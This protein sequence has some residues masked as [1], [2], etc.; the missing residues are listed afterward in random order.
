MLGPSHQFGQSP[1]VLR[2]SC[3]RELKL[4]AAGA[5]KAQSAKPQNALEVREQHLDLLARAPRLRERLS[6]GEGTGDIACGFVHIADDPSRGHVRA[7]LR[8]ER[9]RA[10]LRPGAEIPQRVIGVDIASRGERLSRRTCIDVAY[11][12][13]VE[14]LA[15]ERAVLTLRFVD[16]WDMRR[17]PPA[18]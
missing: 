8:F 16:D 15:R 13:V 9:A 4:R 3:Q 17:D 18:R 7:A 12:V 14:V 11:L 10:T 1:Q 2:D 6:F 5:A